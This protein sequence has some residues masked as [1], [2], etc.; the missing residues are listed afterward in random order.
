MLSGDFMLPAWSDDGTQIAVAERK[1]H[2]KKW[3]IYVV[4]V[5]PSLRGR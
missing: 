1:N 4:T 3:E 5:P 2:G